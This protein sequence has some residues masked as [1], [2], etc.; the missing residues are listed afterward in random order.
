MNTMLLDSDGPMTQDNSVRLY[1]NH[2]TFTEEGELLG[3]EDP[4]TSCLSYI[5]IFGFFVCSQTFK[6]T[7]SVLSLLAVLVQATLTK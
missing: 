3:F 4:A 7:Q 1:D 6:S 5:Y 2:R